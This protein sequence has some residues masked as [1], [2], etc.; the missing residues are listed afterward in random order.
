M[1]PEHSHLHRRRDEL[2]LELTVRYKNSLTIGGGEVSEPQIK[3]CLQHLDALQLP[4][5]GLLL[6]SMELSFCLSVLPRNKIGWNA[7]VTG[8]QLFE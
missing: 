7:I 2:W 6:T 5:F 1:G 8:T 3:V 4:T